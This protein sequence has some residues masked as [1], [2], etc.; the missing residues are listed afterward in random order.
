[1]LR[2]SGPV[3]DNRCRTTNLPWVIRELPLA[4][5]FAIPRYDSSMIEATAHGILPNTG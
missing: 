4:E 2:R 1:M 5:R 3:I